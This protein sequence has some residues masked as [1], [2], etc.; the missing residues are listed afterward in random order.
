MYGHK[1]KIEGY[2]LSCISIKFSDQ[3]N[4]EDLQVDQ[5]TVTTQG[6]RKTLKLDSECKY[7]Q[8]QSNETAPW[9]NK[10]YWNEGIL[11]GDEIP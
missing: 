8:I 7:V 10:Y 5:I 11:N 3:V 9:L 6:D 2:S 4:K 1:D